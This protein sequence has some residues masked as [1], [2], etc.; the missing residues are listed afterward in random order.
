MIGRR[1]IIAVVSFLSLLLIFVFLFSK[2]NY[3]SKVIIDNNVFT[4][5]I[6]ETS[7]LM[8]RGLSGRSSLSPNE[9]MF[10]V[11]QNPGHYGFWMKDMNFP[12]DIVWIDE[13][14]KIIGFQKKLSPETY[15]NVFYPDKN[16][17][18]VLEISTGRADEVGM[19]VGD[20][21]KWLRGNSGNA[22][23]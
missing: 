20:S 10:F 3:K 9:G 11:F 18:F 17:L 5:D 6:A 23:F 8:Q 7:Y 4:V 16:V 2:I 13:N 15:P 19:R 21:V 12:I 22:I 1:I 14:L